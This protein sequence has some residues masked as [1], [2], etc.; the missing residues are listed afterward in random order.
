MQL[1]LVLIKIKTSSVKGENLTE[2]LIAQ[3]FADPFALSMSD[4]WGEDFV[5]KPGKIVPDV[6]RV[7]I[8]GSVETIPTDAFRMH[9]VLQEVVVKEGVIE[10]GE[11]AFIWCESLEQLALPSTLVRI[12]KLA[13]ARTSLKEVNLPENIT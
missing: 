3:Q 7:I 4:N 8:P 5:Y 10:V 1:R 6:V 11:N 9:R 2:W 13:F 12:G